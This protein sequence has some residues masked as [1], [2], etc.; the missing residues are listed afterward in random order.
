MFLLIMRG[1]LMV[2]IYTSNKLDAAACPNDPD[3]IYK[4]NSLSACLNNVRVLTGRHISNP[5]FEDVVVPCAHCMQDD[6]PTAS[7]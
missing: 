1:F 7:E 4:N 2:Y 5:D 3:N 6:R